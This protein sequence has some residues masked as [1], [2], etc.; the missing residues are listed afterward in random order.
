MCAHH[1][2]HMRIGAESGLGNDHLVAVVEKGSAQYGENVVSAVAH[3]HLRWGDAQ[4]LR[5]SAHQRLRPAV[6]IAVQSIK[7]AANRIHRAGCGAERILVAGEL[8]DFAQ[9]VLDGHLFDGAPRNIGVK[10]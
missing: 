5:Q 2:T 10:R 3:E 8:D 4:F 9:P 7:R 6:G 1:P